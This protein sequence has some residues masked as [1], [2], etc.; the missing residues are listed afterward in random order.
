MTTNIYIFKFAKFFLFMIMFHFFLIACLSWYVYNIMIVALISIFYMFIYSVRQSS[1]T[2][3]LQLYFIKYF[4]EIH[5]TPFKKHIHK[6]NVTEYYIKFILHIS[7]T[8]V[9]ILKLKLSLYG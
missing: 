2:I 5:T 7:K 6:N 1:I 4:N 3:V 9:V 8:T